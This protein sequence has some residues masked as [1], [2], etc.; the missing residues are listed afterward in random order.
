V[1]LH[2]EPGDSNVNNSG[3]AERDDLSTSQSATD[4]YEGHEQWWAHSILFPDDYVIPPAGATWN[5]G[6]VMDFHHTGPTG[7]ANFQVVS[8]PTGLVFQGF[9]GPTVANSPS[10]PGFYGA[11]IGPVTKNAWY[12]FVYHVKWSSGSDGYFYAW[13]NGVQKLAHTGPTL[14]SG[15]GCYLKLANYHTAVGLPVSVIH[16]RVI[17]GTSAAAVALTPLR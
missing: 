1:R 11:S 17:R 12:D 3:T 9:G 2:T 7:Q 6:V 5:W 14:Y 13:V 8:L 15:Q 10:D 16:D 4:C